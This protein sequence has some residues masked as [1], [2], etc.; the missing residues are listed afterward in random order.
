[1]TKSILSVLTVSIFALTALL[2]ANVN[3]DQIGYNADV[4]LAEIDGGYI[5]DIERTGDSDS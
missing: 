4:N 3:P 2:A 1:M 5:W